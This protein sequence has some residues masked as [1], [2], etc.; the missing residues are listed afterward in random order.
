M[1]SGHLWDNVYS[2]VFC[3]GWGMRISELFSNL[4]K[5]YELIKNT[6]FDRFT[7][8]V[9]KELSELGWKRVPTVRYMF[10]GRMGVT[11]A[12][13]CPTTCYVKEKERQG[14]SEWYKDLSK[15]IT[16]DHTP[17]VMTKVLG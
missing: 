13:A 8:D 17:G 2:K 6:K 14:G 7:P 15:L 1:P 4:Q 11:G 5:D 16:P 12:V 9:E 3:E 10:Y